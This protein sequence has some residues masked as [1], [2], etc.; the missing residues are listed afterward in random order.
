MATNNNAAMQA[1]FMQAMRNSAAAINQGERADGSPQTF[2]YPLLDRY[3]LWQEDIPFLITKAQTVP[4]RNGPAVLLTC[5]NGKT[6]ETFVCF[7]GRY[8]EM[9]LGLNGQVNDYPIPSDVLVSRAWHFVEREL[10]ADKK[11]STKPALVLAFW[12]PD[13]LIKNAPNT[14]E[15]NRQRVAK[16]QASASWDEIEEDSTEEFDSNE[17]FDLYDDPSFQREVTKFGE[18]FQRQIA[19]QRKALPKAQPAKKAASTQPVKKAVPQGPEPVRAN[20]I[21]LV[22]RGEFLPGRGRRPTGAVYFNR[23]DGRYYDENK[24]P[25]GNK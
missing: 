19:E 15:V 23:K 2:E 25:L 12:A 22:G 18:P 9:Q 24:K 1:R 21:T 17:E 8:V 16:Q 10:S 7:S 3:T 4:T 11:R 13:Q 5:V 20:A 6:L 14:P